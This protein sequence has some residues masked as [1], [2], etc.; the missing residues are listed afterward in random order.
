MYQAQLKQA[1][2]EGLGNARWKLLQ[3]PDLAALIQHQHA[4]SERPGQGAPLAD[5]ARAAA[6]LRRLP[7]EGIS[8]RRRSS[9]ATTPTAQQA[10]N[11]GRI[12]RL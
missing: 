3:R 7:H 5:L 9:Q 11:W 4:G 2:Q 10:S 12:E 8:S 1:R 6:V